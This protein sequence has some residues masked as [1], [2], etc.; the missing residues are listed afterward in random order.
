[1]TDKAWQVVRDKEPKPG[2]LVV[3]NRSEQYYVGTVGSEIPMISS[4]LLRD[5]YLELM[6]YDEWLAIPETDKK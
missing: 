5:G 6:P 4:P 2:E 1:M 3:I